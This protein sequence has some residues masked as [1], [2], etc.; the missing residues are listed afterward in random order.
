MNE[1]ETR[2]EHITPAFKVAGWG[3]VEGPKIEYEFQVRAGK[4]KGGDRVR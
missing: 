2:S 4:E 3:V 1:Y